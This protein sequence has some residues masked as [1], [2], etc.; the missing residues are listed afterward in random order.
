MGKLFGIFLFPLQLAVCQS[1][2]V[3]AP[4]SP[5][6]LQSTRNKFKNS[7]NEFIELA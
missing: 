3:F 5:F 7:R 1:V 4:L 2:I 6:S